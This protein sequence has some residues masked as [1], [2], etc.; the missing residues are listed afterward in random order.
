MTVISASYKLNLPTIGEIP[1]QTRLYK[2]CKHELMNPDP[3]TKLNH[4]KVQE[5]MTYICIQT[6]EI[7][8]IDAGRCPSASP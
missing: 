3:T 4:E 8:P 7:C 1:S 2:L 5:S 6:P